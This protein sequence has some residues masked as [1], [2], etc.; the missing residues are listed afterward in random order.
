MP[1]GYRGTV[2]AIH[3]ARVPQRDK[4]AGSRSLS[5]RLKLPAQY[6]GTTVLKYSST[7]VPC[8]SDTVYP[9]YYMPVV[10]ELHSCL[11]PCDYA[12][13]VPWYCYCNLKC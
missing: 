13:R 8:I 3:N 10:P 11:V 9:W 5:T 12:L 7:R 1:S 4:E 6:Y 2:G